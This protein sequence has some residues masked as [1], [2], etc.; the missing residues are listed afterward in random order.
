M[1]PWVSFSSNGAGVLAPI[2]C[3]AKAVSSACG[4][5]SN[6]FGFSSASCSF[7][8]VHSKAEGFSSDRWR[9]LLCM[10][11]SLAFA[12]IDFASWSSDSFSTL[13]T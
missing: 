8:T 7:N 2:M 1:T 5:N 6:C 4:F 12:L 3:N 9:L 11:T 10:L 13:M